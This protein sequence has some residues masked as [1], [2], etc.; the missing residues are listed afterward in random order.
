MQW[1]VI[2]TIILAKWICKWMKLQDIYYEQIEV[3]EQSIIHYISKLQ[4]SD[5]TFG[6]NY[7]YM[8]VLIITYTVY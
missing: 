4:Y 5:I 3:F 1:N 8:S 7:I 2:I 6:I